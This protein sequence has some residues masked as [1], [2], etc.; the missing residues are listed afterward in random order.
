MKV[1]ISGVTG[2]I[3]SEIA[4]RLVEEDEH[5]VAALVR[6]GSNLSMFEPIKDIISNL[7]VRYG[8]L[9]DF[10]SIKRIVKDVSPQYIL[11]IGAQTS[12]RHSFELPLEYNETNYMGTINLAHAALE[13]NSF[14]K[15][16]FASTMETYGW[17]PKKIPFKEDL[18]LNPASPYAASKVACEV[19]IRM[20]QKAFGLPYIISRACNTFG[21]K[22]NSGFVTEYLITTMLKNRTVYLGT[23]NA[24]RDMMY[25][26]DHVNAYLKM[27]KSN[28]VNDT[29]NFGTGSRTKMKEIAEKVRKF[30]D[31]KGK[32]AYSFPPNYPWRPVVEDFL[33]LD[34]GRA[35]KK[36]GWKPKYSLDEGLRKSIEYWKENLSR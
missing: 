31:F 14:K 20:A 33:S 22:H 34:S 15:F 27:L 4:R 36:L 2:F 8:N 10:H 18:S 19:Y 35:R 16:I 1:L 29:F 9:S 23:P 13:L 3:G 30:T 6:V 26:D 28:A 11:H 24:V 25:V 21:R 7:D 17:Q 5:E 32:I 12:V